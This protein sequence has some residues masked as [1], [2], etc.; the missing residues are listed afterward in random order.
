MRHTLSPERSIEIQG[1]LDSDIQMQLDEC[2]RLP[3]ERAEIERAMEMSLRWAERSAKA[4]GEEGKTAIRNIRR[5][6]IDKVKKMEKD[7]E[8]S[9]DEQRAWSEEVQQMTDDL[10]AKIDEAATAKEEEILQV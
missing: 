4:F 10:V 1:L 2:I 5:D 9:Q 6:A 7:G 3:A 8:M